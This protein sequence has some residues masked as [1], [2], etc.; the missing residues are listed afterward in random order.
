M[1]V[2]ATQILILVASVYAATCLAAL[3]ASRRLRARGDSYE[4]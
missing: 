4:P 3:G 1:S 2:P